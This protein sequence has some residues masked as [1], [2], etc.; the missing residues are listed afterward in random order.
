MAEK[1]LNVKVCSPLKLRS[2]LTG[3]KSA[4]C[5]YSY[6]LPLTPIVFKRKDTETHLIIRLTEIHGTQRKFT[7]R[8]LWNELQV[9]NE[10]N[11]IL[12]KLTD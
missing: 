4:I 6:K 10:Y 11:G 9:R 5:H 2:G 12:R 8:S 7:E 1:V 3:K